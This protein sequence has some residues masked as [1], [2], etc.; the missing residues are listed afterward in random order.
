M[1]KE[2]ENRG[3]QVRIFGTSDNPVQYFP[4]ANVHTIKGSDGNYGRVLFVVFG[5]ALGYNHVNR[6]IK[7][8]I[9]DF[10]LK[11]P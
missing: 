9:F 8:L 2:G 1:G 7:R 4:V 3:F 11:T 6:K 5:D 10:E